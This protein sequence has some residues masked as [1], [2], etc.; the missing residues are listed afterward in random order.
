MSKS[1]DIRVR[2]P[3]GLIED[4]DKAAAKEYK[5]RSQWVREAILEKLL[6]SE[7]GSFPPVK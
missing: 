2:V 4:A 3:N 6:R 5:G 7:D 1:T